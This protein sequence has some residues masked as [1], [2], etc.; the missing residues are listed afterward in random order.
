MIAIIVLIAVFV[1]IAMRH[2]GNLRFQIWQIMLFGAIAVLLT[3]QI[4]PMD[5]LKSIN[6][7]VMLFL[8]GMFVVG[9]GA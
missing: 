6:I 8:F 9:A 7:D 3:G 4:S 1:L 5:A 2:V